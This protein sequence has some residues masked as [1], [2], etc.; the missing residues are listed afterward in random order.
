MPVARPSRTRAACRQ[1]LRWI[2]AASLVLGAVLVRAADAEAGD[3]MAVTRVEHWA[4]APGA[5]PSIG[6]PA[7][8]AAGDWL[9]VEL[10][11]AVQRDPTTRAAVNLPRPTVWY[12]T[13]C[14][15]PVAQETLALYLPRVNGGPL[16]VW[17]RTAQ[18]TRQLLDNSPAWPSQW[19][20]PILLR[21]PGAASQSP[22][23]CRLFLALPPRAD[24]SY[25]LSRLWMGPEPE[26]QALWSARQ[27]WVVTVPLAAST[28]LVMLGLFSLAFWWRRRQDTA[29]LYFGLASLA[30][31]FRNLH[32]GIEL[33]QNLDALRW[34]WWA[35]DAS[36]TWV[37]LLVYLFSLRFA[38]RSFPSVERLLLGFALLVSAVSMP[39][40][41]WALDTPLLLHAANT[42]VAMGVTLL[43]AWSAWRGSREL[44]VL[45]V[46]LCICLVLGVHDLALLQLRIS[47][48]KP[49]PHALRDDA[50]AGRLPVRCEPPLH[51]RPGACRGRGRG[52]L[53]QA[54]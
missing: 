50:G 31:W 24:G 22:G 52:A 44:R 10:P 1:G 25:A 38:T 40:L 6:P 21:L 41:P 27:R 30:W 23:P 12:R 51:Q 2:V 4:P 43:I 37:M 36:M 11:Q 16:Q 26:V 7:D 8:A 29:Y 47:P 33:P 19:N 14:P 39:F 46:A 20:Q 48:R 28:T 53:E 32:Y 49:V 34:F 54:R 3:T 5:E 45:A 15:A 9:P 42:L 18:G 13:A 17:L 35:T